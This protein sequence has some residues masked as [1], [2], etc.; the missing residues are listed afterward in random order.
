MERRSLGICGLKGIA[1]GKEVAGC[2]LKFE[3]SK[4]K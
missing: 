2:L 4:S 3:E 1:T